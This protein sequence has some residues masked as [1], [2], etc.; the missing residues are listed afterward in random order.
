[1]GEPKLKSITIS[2]N[3]PIDKDGGDD[4]NLLKNIS[5]GIALNGYTIILT[6]DDETDLHFVAQTLDEV[7]DLIRTHH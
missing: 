5:I 6:F 4:E 7:F 3:G 1:M 2:Q